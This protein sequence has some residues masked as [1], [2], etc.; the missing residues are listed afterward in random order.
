[1]ATTPYQSLGFLGALLGAN[2]VIS[3]FRLSETMTLTAQNH[4]GE[5]LSYL[6]LGSII[7]DFFSKKENPPFFLIP[8]FAFITGLIY[9]PLSYL[10][11]FNFTLLKQLIL[12]WTI[13]SIPTILFIG[14]P[15]MLISEYFKRK[16]NP[17]Y[18]FTISFTTAII[19][20][21]L[22][23]MLHTRYILEATQLLG[24]SA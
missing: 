2:I 17:I 5:A 15:I 9:Q 18:S 20:M 19:T 10:V 11:L 7:L 3:L 4:I 22:F 12:E 24:I 16:N 14:L 23:A 1:M 21:S 6:L 8:I 13:Y